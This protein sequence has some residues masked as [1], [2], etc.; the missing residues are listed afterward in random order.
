MR[1]ASPVPALPDPAALYD[2]HAALYA[3]FRLHVFPDD[4]RAIAAAL[5]L[6]AARRVAEIGCGPGFYA[7][8][9]AAS[10]PHL[11]VTGIDRAAGQL[12]IARQRAR[13]LAN[14]TF[15]CGD[16]RALGR[17]RGTFDRVIAPRLLMVV[18]QRERAVAEMRRAL[19]PRGLLLLAEPLH[20][21][22]VSVL[23]LL[24]ARAG[25]ERGGSALAYE[26]LF[27]ATSFAALVHGQPWAAAAI[28]EANGYRYA[29]CQADG[30]S[31]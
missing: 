6:P 17:W 5:D 9:F 2:R 28:W 21:P 19:A 18:P 1:Y 29:R 23:A 20:P 31:R 26:H 3:A 12:A 15:L 16:V 24:R 4:R 13:G 8:S 7:T 27:T 25:M 22:P 10:Y 30:S 11:T 14:I